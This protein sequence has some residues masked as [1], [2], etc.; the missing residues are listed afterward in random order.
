MILAVTRDIS[1]QFEI[2][3]IGLQLRPECPDVTGSA[4]LAGLH[5]K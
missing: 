2:A 3:P 5:R 1:M 4:G